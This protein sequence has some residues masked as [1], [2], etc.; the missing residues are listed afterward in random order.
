MKETENKTTDVVS[1]DILDNDI[2]YTLVVNG[3]NITKEN[4]AEHLRMIHWR[5]KASDINDA[6][7]NICAKD[8]ISIILYYMVHKYTTIMEYIKENSKSL[9]EEISLLRQSN[10]HSARMIMT[11]QNK[12]I[13]VDSA[14]GEWLY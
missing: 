12:I 13:D 6:Y 2:E 8:S 5:T 10:I 4:V 11:N 14:I 1:N 9:V 7:T 3:T